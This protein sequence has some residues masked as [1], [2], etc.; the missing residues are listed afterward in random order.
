MLDPKRMV[1]G[2]HVYCGSA[3]RGAA[4]EYGALPTEMVP[5][6][7]S[8]GVKQ[9]HDSTGVWI[10]TGDV[11]A[12][13]AIVIGARQSEIAGYRFAAVLAGNDVVDLERQQRVCL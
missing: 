12:L 7:V 9:P 13:E 2:Q 11:R 6:F 3:N 10:E 1:D 5:P 8:A 4:Y